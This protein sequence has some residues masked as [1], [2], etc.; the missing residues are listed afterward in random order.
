MSPA[1]G[2]R[3]EL[4]LETSSARPSVAARWEGRLEQR[5]LV[6][7]RPHASDLLPALEQLLAGL[8]AGPG[9]VGAVIVG[10]GPGSYTGLRVGVATALGIARGA[11]A[12]LHG[13]PSLEALSYG[14]LLPGASAA[15]LLDARQGELYL[16]R[17]RREPEEVQALLAPCVTT[18]AA[19]GE[20]VPADER[21]F[22]DEAA[23]Q[24]AGL[25]DERARNPERFGHAW[26]GAGA[27]LRLGTARLG[28]RGPHTPA[29]VEP[30]YLRA[31]A[32]RSRRR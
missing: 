26:P 23:L 1:G 30:L 13:V 19:L 31:F 25:E 21:I 7:D 3:L 15:F 14:E 9:D 29:Q 6:G 28:H 27:L 16:A 12:L 2:P 18:A 4:A 11:G 17:Y 32:A 5:S 24:A 20:L 10:T 8:G 22:A